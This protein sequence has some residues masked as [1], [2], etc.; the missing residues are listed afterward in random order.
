MSKTK[1]QKV[2]SANMTEPTTE[3]EQNT[4]FGRALEVAGT[5]KGYLIAACVLGILSTALQFGPA[6]FTYFA[7]VE[8]VSSTANHSELNTRRI[9]DLALYMIGCFAGG[10]VLQY[11][12]V[13]LSHI[14]AFKIIYE[15]QMA[16]AGK[17]SR[18]SLG[19]FT[20]TTSGSIQTVMFRHTQ[21]LEQ[22]IAHHLVD[23]ASAI[24][25]PLITI[26]AMCVIDWRLMLAAIAPLPFAVARYARYMASEECKSLTEQYYREI[27]HLNSGAVEFVNGMPVVKI[28]SRAGAAVGRFAEEIKSHA[29][30]VSDCVSR[31]DWRFAQSDNSCG[32]HY[33][34]SSY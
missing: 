4:G 24:A 8:I 33:R 7:V 17:L 15:L 18:L 27:A 31:A 2:S 30:M 3:A 13:M 28:F 21:H 32:C 26:I 34:S 11:V 14:A 12:S 20:T 25:I 22:F 19:Y 9:K 10:A 5:K 23:L 16:L 6:I 29:K 1:P